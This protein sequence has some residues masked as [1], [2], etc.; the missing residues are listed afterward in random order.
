MFFRS[1]KVSE[2]VL[3]DP[4][5]DDDPRIILLRK[6]CPRKACLAPRGFYCRTTGGYGTLHKARDPEGYAEWRNRPYE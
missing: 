2:E 6:P 1:G 3:N 4:A 5:N